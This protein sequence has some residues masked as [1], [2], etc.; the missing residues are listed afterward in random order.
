[1]KGNHFPQSKNC[2]KT[3]KEKLREKTGQKKPKLECQNLRSYLK[4]RSF[5][6]GNNLPENSKLLPDSAKGRKSQS[7]N[8]KEIRHYIKCLEQ[9]LK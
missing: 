3:R 2:L 4:T 9:R 8:V 6:L 5:L 1:M 7:F